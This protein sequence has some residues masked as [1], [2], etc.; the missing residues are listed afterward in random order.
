MTNSGPVP[1]VPWGTTRESQEEVKTIHNEKA[2]TFH[3]TLEAGVKDAGN[4]LALSLNRIDGY[5][6]HRDFSA[7]STCQ[8]ACKSMDV[9]NR[10]I[11]QDLLRLNAWQRS[12]KFALEIML[13]HPCLPHLGSIH[14]RAF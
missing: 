1:F 11:H 8:G 6:D 5:L 13:V 12:L 9:I 10:I 14:A 2:P 7:L 3:E 4:L